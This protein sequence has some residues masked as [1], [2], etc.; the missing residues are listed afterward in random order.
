MKILIKS[1]EEEQLDAWFDF[2][3]Q[4]FGPYREYFVRHFYSDPHRSLDSIFVAYEDEESRDILGTVRVYHRHVMTDHPEN[5]TV[6][7]RKMGGIGEVSTRSDMRGRGIASRLLRYANEYMRINGFDLGVLR[8]SPSLIEFYSSV[9]DYQSVAMYDSLLELQVVNPSQMSNNRYVNVLSPSNFGQ[10]DSLVEQM[11]QL[12]S[13]FLVENKL[14]GPIARTGDDKDYWR[15]WVN[16]ELESLGESPIIAYDGDQHVVG[17]LFLHPIDGECNREGITLSVMEFSARGNVNQWRMF[18]ELLGTYLLGM[19][20]G[21]Q[22]VHVKMP[23]PLLTILKSQMG[24]R[25]GDV[26][27]Q[28]ESVLVKSINEKYVCVTDGMYKVMSPPDSGIGTIS[29]V[30]MFPEDRHMFWQTDSF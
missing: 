6:V 29:L 7:S 21:D 9:A 23:F 16:A 22:T 20:K 24:N 4:V 3:T 17:Y 28:Q 12:H 5:G 15:L 1:L 18:C 11:S 8:C 2:V 27:G 30:D 10:D 26:T 14:C 25:D 13:S 19:K